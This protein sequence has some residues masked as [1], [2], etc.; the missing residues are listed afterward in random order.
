MLF[1]V[2]PSVCLCV[3]ASSEKKLF[4]QKLCHTKIEEKEEEKKKDFLS[5]LIFFPRSKHVRL[6][7]SF[8][9]VL[10]LC[11]YFSAN[12]NSR[13]FHFLGRRKKEQ[14]QCRELLFFALLP[15][16]RSTSLLAALLIRYS[17]NY[18]SQYTHSKHYICKNNPPEKKKT[19]AGLAKTS[20]K[21]TTT[22]TTL[23]LL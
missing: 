14:K 2:L 4:S 19:A 6:N 9:F 12:F 7:A 8:S 1:C 21:T 20:S 15:G 3:C 17:I 23:L 16:I 10:F 13:K 22:T 11:P 18:S 5:F